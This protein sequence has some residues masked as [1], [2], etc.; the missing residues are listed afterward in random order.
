ML[1]AAESHKSRPRERTARLLGPGRSL[2]RGWVS[3]L[4][5][6]EVIES[7]RRSD[8]RIGDRAAVGFRA[9]S[10]VFLAVAVIS[11]DDRHSRVRLIAGALLARR[12]GA[13]LVVV[14][15]RAGQLEDLRQGVVTRGLTER[16]VSRS[17]DRSQVGTDVLDPALMTEI[18]L[19][20]PAE[21][22]DGV[23]PLSLGDLDAVVRVHRQAFPDS[24]VTLL[25]PQVVDRYYRWQ[26]IGSHPSPFAAGSWRNGELVGFVFGGLRREAVTGYARR[27]LP[28]ILLGAITHPR[29]LRALAGPKLASVLRLMFRQTRSASIAA[30]RPAGAASLPGGPSFGILS[31]AVSP[32]ARGSGVADDLMSAAES[33]AIRRGFELM[34]LTVNPDNRRAIR[35]YER[36]G[37]E[38]VEGGEGWTGRM[39]KRIGGPAG[40]GG[41]SF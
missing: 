34:N 26:F 6:P 16:T 38:R 13:P 5:V 36:L 28:M 12:S 4:S 2:F 39:I 24:A 11:G 23:R 29:G 17:V 35:F 27:F 3:P 18:G 25:G 7:L 14:E 31:I 21:D 30:S 22:R 33:A 19:P 1:P 20:P 37:W 15:D 41:G 10:R 32:T 9:D 8:G 40:P